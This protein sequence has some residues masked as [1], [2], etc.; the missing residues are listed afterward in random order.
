MSDVVM[1]PG[2]TILFDGDSLTSRRRPGSLDTWPY[3]RLMNWDRGYA[4]EMERLL[5]CLRPDLRL[6]FRNVAIGGYDS[7]QML[8]KFDDSVLPWEPELVI[9][10]T[11]GNDASRQ[12]PLDEFRRNVATYCERVRDECGGRV[13]FVGGFR[14]CPHMPAEKGEVYG[15]RMRYYDV[16][17]EVAAEYGGRYVDAGTPLLRKAEELY[18]QAEIHTVYSDGGHFNAVGN[19]IIAAAV[20]AALGFDWQA[21]AT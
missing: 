5:F 7:G 21:L 17:Q 2:Q 8:G 6:T 11:G 16:Q 9:L 13:V 4:D 18:E 12:M 10:T 3:L 1:E 20:L 19:T 14:P 15:R